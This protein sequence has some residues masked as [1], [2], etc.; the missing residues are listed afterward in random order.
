LPALTD[1]IPD[2]PLVLIHGYS[3][4]DHAFGKWR[5][6]FAGR[7]IRN[8]HVGKYVSLSNEV[9]IKDIAEGL[10]R[11]LEAVGI[12]GDM[13]FD[14]VV[15]STGML[16]IRS[17]LV[18]YVERRARLKHLIGLA[19]ASF[20]SPLAHKGRSWLG[21]VFKGNREIGP[22]FLE[23]GDEVLD[24]L[25]LGSRFTWDLAE[26]DLFGSEPM[27]GPDSTTPYVF[28][29]CGNSGYRGIRGWVS[30]EG[31][32]GTVRF[33]GCSLNSR[34]LIVDLTR[35]PLNGATRAEITDWKNVSNIPL[36]FVDGRDHGSIMND[37]PAELQDLVVDA[38]RVDDER[39]LQ[40]WCAKA[41]EYGSLGGS[42]V[43]KRWQQFVVRLV[44]E[45]RDPVPDYN[46]SLY[47][48]RVGG[49]ETE[50]ASFRKDVH[51]Y[52]R[53]KSLRNFHVDVTALLDPAS[54][55]RLHLRLIASSGSQL[56]GY[57]GFSSINH[58]A[59]GGLPVEEVCIDL[60]PLLQKESSDKDRSFRF[61]Y[62]NTT[63]LVEIRTNREPLPYPGTNRVY[64]FVQS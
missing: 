34:K 58:D 14:A 50:L 13:P 24:A 52:E 36:V 19:P 42:K 40:A 12:G 18:T 3:S 56:V 38:L 47:V 28:I 1:G 35:A 64:E 9:T 17:W 51:A 62:P 5:E 45:R 2:R 44:D 41:E 23:A 8:V 37:P 59:D 61:F 16:V 54:I 11:A 25:E 49:R 29:F 26:R 33:A 32:D 20:G 6:V 43:R 4:S 60:K 53:D 63:T 22:D 15:H 46:A 31:T 7:Q 55:E 48:K 10:D 21:K 30:E 57:R 27:Y 39:G